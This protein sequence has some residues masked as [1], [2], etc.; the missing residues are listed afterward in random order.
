MIRTVSLDISKTH[1]QDELV[2]VMADAAMLLAVASA[3]AVELKTG[4]RAMPLRAVSDL[5][6][7]ALGYVLED[8]EKVFGADSDK[9]KA[10]FIADMERRKKEQA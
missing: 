2:G 8:F 10:M 7:Q 1:S 3:M 9:A 6:K 4:S 5:A